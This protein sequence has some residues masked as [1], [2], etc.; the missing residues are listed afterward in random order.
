MWFVWMLSKS[1]GTGLFFICNNT[2]FVLLLFIDNLLATHQWY[3]LSKSSFASIITSFKLNPY[4]NKEVSS[5]NSLTALHPTALY[6]SLMYN[7]KNNGPRTD[8]WGTPHFT[9]PISD[10][11]P[12]STVN[13][14]LLIRY[15]LENIFAWPR[16]PQQSNFRNIISWSTVSN[17]FL[18]SINIPITQFLS[19]RR[20]LIL[21]V[22]SINAIAVEYN[23]RNPY[24]WQN[25]I[26]F[27]SKNATSIFHKIFSHILSKWESKLIGL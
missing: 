12:L 25:N 6:I 11:T 7:K 27:C 18:K 13:W 9:K 1:F 15:D 22:I 2:K 4:D 24:W 19:S 21:S 14:R 5:A 23:F 26:C 20:R 8:P 17:A 3:N 10:Y 16:I